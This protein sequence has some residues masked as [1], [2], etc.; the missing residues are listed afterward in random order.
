M[1]WGIEDHRAGHAVSGSGRPARQTTD[2]HVVLALPPHMGQALPFVDL[3]C[4][5]IGLHTLDVVDRRTPPGPPFVRGGRETGRPA[6]F[7]P[8]YEG[9]ARGG[10]RIDHE[11]CATQ[12]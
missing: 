11:A 1:R 10:L 5:T 2:H 4:F 7:S 8:P 3:E 6:S 12:S 9:G